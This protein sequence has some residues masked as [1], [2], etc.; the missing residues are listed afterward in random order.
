MSPRIFLRHVRLALGPVRFLRQQ[1]AYDRAA[2]YGAELAACL[3]FNDAWKA[4]SN[5]WP[6]ETP[7]HAV[8]RRT[9]PPSSWIG[10]DPSA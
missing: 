10:V 1:E 7:L 9:N 4:L 6:T 5:Y 8:L 3:G 2:L